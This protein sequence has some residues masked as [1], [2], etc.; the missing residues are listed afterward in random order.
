MDSIATCSPEDRDLR[1]RPSVQNF[2]VDPEERGVPN[3]VWSVCDKMQQGS[4]NWKQTAEG[5]V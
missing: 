5:D 4:K 1:F 3:T 2:Q